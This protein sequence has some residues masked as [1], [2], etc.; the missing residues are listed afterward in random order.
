MALRSVHRALTALVF[1]ALAARAVA[2][3]VLEDK[4]VLS[5]SSTRHATS[6]TLTELDSHYSIQTPAGGI[7]NDRLILRNLDSQLLVALD[8][9]VDG[10]PDLSSADGMLA[11]VVTDAMSPEQK[12]IA[13]WKFIVDWR[14][15]YIPAQDGDEIHD[16]VKLI[17][18]YGYGFC[19]DSSAAITALSRA[20]GMPARIWGLGGHVVA[21]VEFDGGWHMFD[22]DH[23]VFYRASDGHILSVEELAADPSAILATPYDPVATQSDLMASMYTSAAD[24]FLYEPTPLSTHRIEP[25]L[26]PLDEA[27]FDLAQGTVYF[28]SAAVRAA[29]PT[30]GPPPSFSNG[31]LT[32]QIDLGLALREAVSPVAWPFPLV[33]GELTLQLSRDAAD[34]DVSITC[35]GPDWQAVPTTRTNQT[36]TASLR[37]FFDRKQTASYACSLRLRSL[38]PLSLAESVSSGEIQWQFQFAARALQ[39]LA[40]GG[41]ALHAVLTPLNR[42][43]PPDWKGVEI[44]HEWTETVDFLRTGAQ[45]FAQGAVRPTDLVEAAVSVNPASVVLTLLTAGAPIEK[46][47]VFL[48]TDLNGATGYRQIGGGADYA[49]ENDRLYAYSGPP[50][51]SQSPWSWSN[52]GAVSLVALRPD[53]I[54][55]TIPTHSLGLIAGGKLGVQVRTWQ[56][57]TT[58]LDE[59]PRGDG[60]WQVSLPRIFQQSG[61]NDTDL[62]RAD[63]AFEASDA[64]IAIQTAS[65]PLD[66][67]HIVLDADANPATGYVYGTLGAEFLIENGVLYRHAGLDQS[68][69]S[70]TAADTVRLSSPVPNLVEARIPIASLNLVSGTRLSLSIHSWLHW[71]TRLDTLPRGAGWQISAPNVIRKLAAKP[72]DL[73]A[74][75]ATI[76][77]GSIV[78][79]LETH[80]LPAQGLHVLLNSDSDSSTGSSYRSSGS[81][82]LVRNSV[83]YRFSGQ[84]PA[85][86]SWTRV[87]S[88]KTRSLGPTTLE[89]VIPTAPMGQSLGRASVIVETRHDWGFTLDSL[90]PAPDRWE[91]GW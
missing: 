75:E 45:R 29:Y 3:P 7:Q 70:W 44:V 65:S 62:I 17:N 85:T 10:R 34:V 23:Q 64:V 72:G 36:I 63:V 60:R 12:A 25:A 49:V 82:F 88:V 90:P 52:I 66:R 61:T 18:V 87:D 35:D 48:D 71:L 19:D 55:L 37:A 46:L 41:T 68:D 21:E 24:N 38:T 47:Q 84:T 22:A 58:Q 78:L 51:A 11:S 20:A 89:V 59:L 15:H 43:V 5:L 50:N 81:D 28:E 91:L 16:P 13:I 2:E 76:Q 40:S 1:L 67:F 54:Q 77:P 42:Q 27:S 79:T 33:G 74:G 8:L 30:Y 86:W 9:K 14:Y 4:V 39:K 32:R 31:T 6:A 69:W 56:D 53:V 57:W 80:Q 83:L 73:V 26:E